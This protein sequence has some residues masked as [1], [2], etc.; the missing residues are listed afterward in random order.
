[1]VDIDQEVNQAGEEEEDRCME[2]GREGL[3]S[4]WKTESLDTFCEEGSHPSTLV[5][6]VPT[7][8][9]LEISARPLLHERSQ[10]GARQAQH[11]TDEP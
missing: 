6:R 8:G 9:C 11:K 3:D 4:N 5:G 7:L 10:K 1:M 2:K